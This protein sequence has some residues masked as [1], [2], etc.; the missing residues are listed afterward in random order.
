MSEIIFKHFKM[1]NK[2]KTIKN[3]MIWDFEVLA[4]KCHDLIELLI[5]TNRVTLNTL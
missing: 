5:V 2:G 1:P 4:P 3:R